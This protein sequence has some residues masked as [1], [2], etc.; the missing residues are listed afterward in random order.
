M[1]LRRAQLDRVRR[2]L[3]QLARLRAA[4]DGDRDQAHDQARDASPDFVEIA[5]GVWRAVRT[6]SA[7][8]SGSSRRDPSPVAD[9][10]DGLERLREL[11]R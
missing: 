10:L 6:I 7:R 9:V 8:S 4:L 5:P 11:C 1:K 3:G 2:D